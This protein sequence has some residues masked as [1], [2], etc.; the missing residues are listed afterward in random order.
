MA[1]YKDLIVFQ[2]ADKLARQIYEI[3][4]RFPKEELYGLTSQIRRAAL[5][6]PTN[7]VE[8]YGRQGKKE[9]KQYV[10]IALGSHAETEYLF[11]FAK[12]RYLKNMNCTKIECL[13]SEVGKLLWGF[14]RS[15]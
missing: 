10:N 5:S 8:G 12:K 9:L 7:I 14:Y 13:I 3:T 6:I 4:K 15:L 1:N 11:T 2:K